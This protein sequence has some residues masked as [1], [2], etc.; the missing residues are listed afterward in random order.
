MSS[1]LSSNHCARFRPK[2]FIQS[3]VHCSGAHERTVLLARSKLIERLTF[4]Y[5]ASLM[6]AMDREHGSKG[7]FNNRGCSKG[8]VV[9]LVVVVD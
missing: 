8:L 2:N 6:L 1:E 7:R 9:L 5:L 3:D 4:A